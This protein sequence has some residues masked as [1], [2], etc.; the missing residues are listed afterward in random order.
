[1]PAL[2]REHSTLLV[3]DVQ[4]RLMPGIWRERFVSEY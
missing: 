3:I 1:M 2:D 4:G